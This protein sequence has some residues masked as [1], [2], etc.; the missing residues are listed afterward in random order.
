[1]SKHTSILAFSLALSGC[2]SIVYTGGSVPALA[3]DSAK[4]QELTKAGATAYTNG[5]FGEAERNFKAALEELKGC[6]ASD[7]R[8]AESYNNLAVLYVNRNQGA[9][10]EPLFEKCLKIKET[11]LGSQDEEVVSAASKLAC[12]Y[13]SNG[14]KDK[15][16]PLVERLTDYGEKEARQLIEVSNSFKKLE[17]YYGQHRKL[18]S[19]EISVKQAEKETLAAMKTQAIE[20]AVMLDSVGT[21]IS[22]NGERALKQSER[23]FKSALSLRQ[24]SLAPN[25]AA[26]ST[27]LENLGKVYQSQ[28]RL[29]LAEPLLRQSLE[30]SL[31]T[32]GMERRETQVRVETFAAIL[33]Q[34]GKL[35]EARALY[36]RALNPDES[37]G[38][39]NTFNPSG[40]FLAGY[41]GLLVKE[42]RVQEALPYYARALKVQEAS[43]GPQHASIATLL[44]SYAYALN[45]ANRKAEASKLIARAR[46]ISK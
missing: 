27:S 6:S 13:L 18:E 42:G 21:A 41:A 46:S 35:S 25:H 43:R 3:L 17:N 15:A 2:I 1:M 33:V 37:A 32:L 16:E 29:A 26:M 30:T 12:Y 24:R 39:K 19:A 44:D 9:K 14:K 8:L 36:Q 45:K 31:K 22:G 28:G 10:A 34:E 20:T 38:K 4:W 40:D 7:I 11:A 23:L 5:N